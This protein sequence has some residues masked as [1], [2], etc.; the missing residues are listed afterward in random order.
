MTERLVVAMVGGH[1]GIVPESGEGGLM[2]SRSRVEGL[3]GHI[4]RSLMTAG[5]FSAGEGM[6][7]TLTF[8]QRFAEVMLR[9]SGEGARE[10]NRGMIVRALREMAM[11]LEMDGLDER[12]ERMN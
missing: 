1:A 9:M 2:V 6:S 4:N 7:A 10:A 11:K 8:A 3:V 5:Q 12:G